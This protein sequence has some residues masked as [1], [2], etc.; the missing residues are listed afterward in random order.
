[1]GQIVGTIW[2]TSYGTR[3]TKSSPNPPL[4]PKGE[5]VGL[6]SGLS[7]NND[8]FEKKLGKICIYVF[9]LVQIQLILLFFG[10]NQPNF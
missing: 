7:S 5:R 1:M 6:L 2:G 4:S 9:F 10:K 8:F 3:K